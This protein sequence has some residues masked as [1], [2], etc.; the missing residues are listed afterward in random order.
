MWMR[1]ALNYNIAYFNRVCATYFHDAENRACKKKSRLIDSSC[2]YAED[3]LKEIKELGG[4]SIYF[5]EYLIKQ[6]ISKA[7]Y[8]IEEGNNKEA[9]K[10]LYKYRYTKLN[11]KAIIKTFI[12]SWIL[13]I[14]ATL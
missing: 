10:L 5:E 4:Y 8:M 2:S 14:Y 12:L 13:T 7:R 3:I 1:I 6:I 11:K 9:R